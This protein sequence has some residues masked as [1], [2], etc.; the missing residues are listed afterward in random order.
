MLSALPD[1][2]TNDEEIWSLFDFMSVKCGQF[3]KRI[4]ELILKCEVHIR[5]CEV[6]LTVS[7][8]K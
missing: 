3:E 5:S 7:S 6:S 8:V 2:V 4:K 1:Y